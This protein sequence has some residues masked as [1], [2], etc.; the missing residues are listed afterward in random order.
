MILQLLVSYHLFDG[1]VIE[2]YGVNGTAARDVNN[3]AFQV[4]FGLPVR[5]KV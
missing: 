4:D 1:H 2:P 5:H 3:F